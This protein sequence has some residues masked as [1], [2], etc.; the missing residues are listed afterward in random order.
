MQQFTA[1]NLTSCYFLSHWLLV[2]VIYILM[3]AIF[4]Y[5]HTKGLLMIQ[6]NI[7]LLSVYV[8]VELGMELID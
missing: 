4:A 2:H 8:N 7:S 5:T 3:F 6:Q 1:I